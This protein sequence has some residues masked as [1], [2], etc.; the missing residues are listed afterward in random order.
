MEICGTGES[1]TA[2]LNVAVIVTESPDL[3]G[4]D[5]EYVIAAVGAVLSTA[6]VLDD[7]VEVTVFPTLSVAVPTVTVTVSLVSQLDPAEYVQTV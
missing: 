7:G 2:S 3:Y 6:K 4:P 5:V 1:T